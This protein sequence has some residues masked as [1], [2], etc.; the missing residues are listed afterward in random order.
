M[1]NDHM[2]ARDWLSEK[3]I[4]ARNMELFAYLADCKFNHVSSKNRDL[5]VIYLLLDI[6]T[7]IRP[8]L[9]NLKAIINRLLDEQISH[10]K[11]FN[12]LAFSTDILPFRRELTLVTL[13]TL[14]SAKD[15]LNALTCG[16]ST[17][18]KL[19]LEY[20]LSDVLTEEVYLITDGRPDQ[21]IDVLLAHFGQSEIPIHTVSF[22]CYDAKANSFLA[23]L[24]K[25]TCGRFHSFDSEGATIPIY[26]IEDIRLLREELLI[27]K[28]SLE[29]IQELYHQCYFKQTEKKEIVKPISAKENTA[30]E[31]DVPNS[32]LKMSK[33]KIR[34]NHTKK[35]GISLV[36]EGGNGLK[37]KKQVENLIIENKSN[38]QKEH[39]SEV[40]KV[41]NS[42]SPVESIEIWLR[43]YGLRTKKLDLYQLVKPFILRLPA[44]YRRKLHDEAFTK[45]LFAK[46]NS[47]ISA[48]FEL[49][50]IYGGGIAAAADQTSAIFITRSTGMK[51]LPKLAKLPQRYQ[52]SR[53]NGVNNVYSGCGPLHTC[54]ALK[55]TLGQANNAETINCWLAEKFTLTRILPS[56][57]SSTITRPRLFEIMRFLGHVKLALCT[58]HTITFISI[59][60]ITQ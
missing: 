15:W 51:L 14:S 40:S 43:K 49:L 45:Q 33:K 24:A 5:K 16:G 56:L 54:S 53:V 50:W 32:P 26:E 58:L 35:E 52:E 34:I 2:S 18:I 46:M 41:E 3:G 44:T 22:H 9:T 31:E 17:N 13:E 42:K 27:G 1:S 36:N 20:A 55:F 6:S 21:P 25:A 11:L 7:S 19:A 30:K 60:T 48:S 59:V 37:N 38:D 12:I 23:S 57:P 47:V 39:K 8:H 28:A 4:R 10:C 29:M